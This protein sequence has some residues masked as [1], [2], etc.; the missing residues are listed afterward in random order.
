MD[1]IVENYLEELYLREEIYVISEDISSFVNKFKPENLSKIK[2][3][4][5]DKL[6]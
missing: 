5:K 3:K 6:K 1:L 2:D 4:L